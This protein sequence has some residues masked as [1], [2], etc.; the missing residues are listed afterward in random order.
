MLVLQAIE[1]KGT[2][3]DDT[4]WLTFWFV[5]TLFSFVKATI[6]FF[7]KWLIPFCTHV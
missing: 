7:F 2:G 3:H 5:Y 6:D 4:H 1:T